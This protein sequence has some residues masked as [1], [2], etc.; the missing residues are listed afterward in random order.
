MNVEDLPSPQDILAFPVYVGGVPI[1]AS[2]LVNGVKKL[3][4]SVADG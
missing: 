1:G 2:T 4:T 3:V